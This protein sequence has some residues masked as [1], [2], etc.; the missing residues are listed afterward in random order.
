MTTLHMDIDVSRS[1]VN[2]MNAT[3][4]A[5]HSQLVGLNNTIEPFVGNSWI[6]PS[7][8]LFSSEF[9]DWSNKQRVLIEELQELARRL[10]R[11]IAEWEAT[12]AQM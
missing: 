9:M 11:E 10:E 12:S 2:Q 7:A 4:D 1:V 8:T 5:L 3:C 6:S